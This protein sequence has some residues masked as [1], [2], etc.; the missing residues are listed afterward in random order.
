MFDLLMI[1]CSC[2]YCAQTLAY[3][4]YICFSSV[5]SLLSLSLSLDLTLSQLAKFALL[6]VYGSIWLASY[7]YNAADSFS[8][9][10]PWIYA[11]NKNDYAV[12]LGWGLFIFYQIRHSYNA[13]NFSIWNCITHRNCWFVCSK[14][15]AQPTIEKE[16]YYI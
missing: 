2:C 11:S 15:N 9:I 3:S 1:F 16:I 5:A 6:D 8:F 10:S 12:I 14:K 13:F 4:N 7:S